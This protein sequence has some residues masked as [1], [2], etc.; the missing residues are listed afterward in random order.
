MP[1]KRESEEAVRRWLEEFERKLETS[2]QE[3]LPSVVKRCP[4]CQRLTLQ[5]DP[6][7]RVVFCSN[8]GFEAKVKH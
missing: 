4:K 7:R 3:K 5:W 1:L 2:A 8:C 6:D